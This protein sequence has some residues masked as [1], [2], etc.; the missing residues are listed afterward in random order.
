MQV[1][2]VFD[3]INKTCSLST[4]VINKR[5]PILFTRSMLGRVFFL[6]DRD[7]NF[8]LFVNRVYR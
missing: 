4:S 6:V 2:Q 3:E 7:L 8:S 5:A 1:C